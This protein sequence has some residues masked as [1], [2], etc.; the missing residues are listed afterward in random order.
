MARTHDGTYILA[1]VAFW[2]AVVG[3]IN[4]G[5]VGFF[6]FDLVRAIFGGDRATD[7]SGLSR[8][9]YALVGLAGLALAAFG[10]RLRA[11]EAG[12][13]PASRAADVRV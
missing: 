9:I 11:R 6:N 5:L 8:L 10:P 1:Q 3:A 4:W 12:R 13:L 2:L 7:M